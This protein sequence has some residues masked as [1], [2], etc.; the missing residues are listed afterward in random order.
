MKPHVE[1]IDRNVF[2]ERL[3]YP[4]TVYDSEDFI[5]SVADDRSRCADITYVIADDGDT[6]IGMIWGLRP[7]SPI[8]FAPF[9]APYSL[10]SASRP[11]SEITGTT[12]DT[13]LKALAV[14]VDKQFNG[15]WQMTLAPTFYA[16]ALVEAMAQTFEST[17]QIAYIDRNYAHTVDAE[18]SSAARRNLRKATQHGTFRLLTDPNPEEVYDLIAEHHRLLSYNMAMTREQ[19]MGTARHVPMDFFMVMD[20]DTP[21]AAAYYQHTAAGIVQMINWGDTTDAR[22]LRV[23]NWMD[24][25]ISRHYADKGISVID[26]GPG[27]NKG[28]ANDGLERFKTSLGCTI[29]PK[30]TISGR[31]V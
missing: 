30:H 3:P 14:F 31:S 28:I 23:T 21:A 24:H 13:L 4:A 10:C 22:P 7:N 11:M 25:A 17:G 29:S 19:V 2:F 20:G 26:L 15:Q 18:L 8:R 9:S 5:R 16:P 6:E 12:F 27:T 1:I